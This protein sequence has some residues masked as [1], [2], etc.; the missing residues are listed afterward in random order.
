MLAD[1]R[2]RV[3]LSRSDLAGAG[4]DGRP[5]R[6]P[7]GPVPP[8]RSPSEPDRRA[9]QRRVGGEPG[10][11]HLHRGT[12]GRPKGV[13]VAHRA[14][15]AARRRDRTTCSCGPGD[16]VAQAS[17]AALRRADLRGLGRAP[18]TGP[19]WWGS[20]GT[21]SSRPAAFAQALREERITTLFLTTAL[22]NQLVARAAGRSSRALREVLFGGEAVDAAQRA[23]AAEGRQARARCCTC[24]APRRRPRVACYEQV[25]HVAED[26]L[27]RLRSAGR[28]ANPRVYVLDAALQP[29]PRGRAGR[30]VRGRRRRGARL[31]GPARADGGA[32]RPRP[33]RARSRARGC[34]ARATGCAGGR[35]GRWSSWAAS[36]SR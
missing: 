31:P 13:M 33:V 22:F 25:E 9:A 11:R 30:A 16:R 21:C 23:A 32:L 15:R 1:S 26:A 6:R 35:T 8:T 18:A 34:T 2:R 5:G 17:N 20:P 7:P 29:V 10:V 19:R 24:T 14:G 4:G 28:S 12:T 27:T 3:L 36:T